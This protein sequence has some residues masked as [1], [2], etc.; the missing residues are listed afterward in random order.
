MGY[1]P[2]ME[3]YLQIKER[4]A[5]SILFYRLGDFYEMF[6]D[7]AKTASKELEL[8]LTG[9][10]CGEGQRAP[11]CGV[12]FHSADSYI[13]RLVAKGY[14]VVVCEQMEDP[15]TA[16]DLVKRDVVRVVTPGT[17]IDNTQLDDTKNN[18]L[19]ALNFVE[20]GAGL[21]FADVS[22]GEMSATFFEGNDTVDGILSQLCL[23]KPSEL[24]VNT[25][26]S[27][28]PKVSEYVK[29]R[30]GS[31][32]TEN[33]DDAFQ[34]SK[35]LGSVSRQ[36]G[37]LAKEAAEKSTSMIGA[38]GA[39]LHYIA[40]TQMTENANISSLSIVE[41]GQYLGL[42]VATRRNLELC[43]T[44][45]S[46]DKK[47]SLLW[48]LDRTKTS[49]GARMLRRWVEQPLINA[50]AIG[51]RQRA[52]AELCSSFMI[53][54]EIAEH[55]KHILDLD[56]LMT[57]L[58][59]G[60]ANAR[61]LRAIAQ[62]ASII[63]EIKD[64]TA[65]FVSEELSDIHIHLDTLFDI[66]ELIDRSI[67]DEPPFSLREGGFIRRGFSPEADELYSIVHD[68][69]SYIERIAEAERE[70][71]GIKNLKISFNRVFGYYIE[72][73]KSNLEQVPERYI[74][75]QTLTN[76]ER[77]ITEELKEKESLILGASDKLCAI[78]YELFCAIREKIA[79]QVK[80]VQDASSLLSKLDCYVSL[81]DV[82][83]RNDYCCPEIEYG[84]TISIK[85]GRHPVVEKFTKDGYFVPNDTLLDT[86]H[87]RLALITGPNMAGKSTYMRQVALITLMAQ[88]GSFVPAKEARIG[89]V[90]K[91][92]TRVGASDDLASG[93]STFML[94][95]NEV[96]YI[97]KNATKRSLIIY[98]EIGRG[99]STFDGMSIARA[100]AEYTAG[101]KIG[102]KTMFATHYHELT[103]L[104]KEI[105]GVVNYN[106]AAKKKNDEITFLRKIVKGATD[107]SYGIEVAKLAGVPNDVIRRAKEVL[108]QLS[109]KEGM[110]RDPRPR[111]LETNITFDDFKADEVR[112]KLLN[113]D[114]NLL[115]PIE[116]LNFL[117][118]LKKLA[119]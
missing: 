115:T 9:R 21:A 7:D 40:E 1:T 24:I 96:A 108:K 83:V 116:A 95:M 90:D 56:R 111:E 52:V 44:M 84:S 82:A 102:A 47:G 65:D 4:Y 25:S 86:N 5:D 75:K 104:D 107:E 91:I 97:L 66:K 79:S 54:E 93:T 53:R 26:L 109:D 73:T 16:K 46:K 72:V 114:V 87:N 51:R 30:I 19:C 34:Y 42:D 28:Y 100:V 92:F 45:R 70:S 77:F 94:E 43:E 110:K 58:V 85:E 12:P 67:V 37:A 31:F 74:R 18:Y 41:N 68:G 23:Y 55:M 35:C 3:Q 27:V 14:K 6:F 62:T 29:D 105:E 76:A 113:T 106:I 8:T 33:R 98:D 32:T 71:T 117:V 112:E 69:K 15:Q 48:V 60:T 64:L 50:S 89:I 49:A 22:T 101:K 13:G 61:D 11:M 59:Y 20:G 88:I 118:E 57:K 103:V 10:N 36:F 81:A 119:E 99:T 63:P 78:E 38:I 39:L 17:V 2:M 80:R